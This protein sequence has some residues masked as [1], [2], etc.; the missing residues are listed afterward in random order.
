M[1]VRG[2]KVH[3]ALQDVAHDLQDWSRNILG[4]LEKRIKRTRK[5]LEERRRGA[6]VENLANRVELLKFKLGKLEE[7]RHMYWR[8]RRK[9]IGCKRVIVTPIFF[10]SMPQ[11]GRE[12]IESGGLSWMTVG[13]RKKEMC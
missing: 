1:E 5:A 11:K 12:E 10:T 8:Q 4:D 3:E 13:W 6:I 7:Q 9:C 2:G